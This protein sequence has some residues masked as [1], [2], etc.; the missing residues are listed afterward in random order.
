[1]SPLCLHTNQLLPREWDHHWPHQVGS[2]QVESILWSCLLLPGRTWKI[3]VNKIMTLFVKKKYTISLFFLF[4]VHAC[5]HFSHI[6]LFVTPWTV[7]HQAPLS[8][9][10]PDKNTGVGC[11]ALLQGIFSNQG[12]NPRLL[13][14]SSEGMSR[15]EAYWVSRGGNKKASRYTS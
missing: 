10:F 6:W 7:A 11:H 9:D 4:Q 3:Y 8:I 14:L 1:M 12:L 13:M 5:C 2:N 15:Q